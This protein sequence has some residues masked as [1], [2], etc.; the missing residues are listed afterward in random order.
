[1][2]STK[3][4]KNILTLID[5]SVFPATKTEIVD[6]LKDEGASR[7]ALAL[8]QTMP[9]NRFEDVKTFSEAIG[10][11]EK[12]PELE[13]VYVT[14]EQSFKNSK[15]VSPSQEIREVIKNEERVL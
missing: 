8:V 1:M 14:E 12:L 3:H 4:S 11:T 13:N 5:G 10:F 9:A 15:E 6:H 2:Q 7:E